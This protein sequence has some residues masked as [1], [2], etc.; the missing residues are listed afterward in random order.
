MRRLGLGMDGAMRKDEADVRAWV[1][2][3]AFEVCQ[4]FGTA[5]AACRYD[6]EAQ[7]PVGLNMPEPRAAWCAPGIVTLVLMQAEHMG[8]ESGKRRLDTAR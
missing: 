8:I 3:P 1:T 2:C 4:E 7:P 6:P 5:R